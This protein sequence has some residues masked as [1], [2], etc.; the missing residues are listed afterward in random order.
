[1]ALVLIGCK[2]S[3][4]Q[5]K[6]ANKKVTSS[7]SAIVSVT[8]SAM[9]YG[10][11]QSLD[12]IVRF[13]VAVNVTG[14]PKVSLTVDQA[15][16]GTAIRDAIYVSGSG[17][18]NLIFRYTTQD[19]DYDLNGILVNSPLLLNN[20]TIKDKVSN[21]SSGLT[22]S[23][24][25]GA[26]TY[27]NAWTKIVSLDTPALTYNPNQALDVTVNFSAPVNVTGI[28]KILLVI[29]QYPSGASTRDAIYLSGSGTANI[30]F[31]YF[32]QD[33]DYDTNGIS[34]NSSIV[35]NGGT[36][37]N[38]VS[39]VQTNLAFSSSTGL[40][41]YIDA[42][43]HLVEFASTSTQKVITEGSTG[44]T[45]NLQITPASL[46]SISI[47]IKK[48]YSSAPTTDHTYSESSV[49][50]SPGSTSAAIASF[51]VIHDNILKT[52]QQL[53]LDLDIGI[54]NRRIILGKKRHFDFNIKDI[55]GGS[56]P[57]SK[58]SSGSQQGCGITFSGIL[59]CW[60]DNFNGQLGDGTIIKKLI[61]T[62][63]D[64]GVT[65]SQISNGYT[66]TCGI[67][68]TGILKC[69]GGNTDGELGDGTTTSSRIPISID[70]GEAYVQVSSERSHTCAI[71]VTGILKCW[72]SNNSGQ[73]GDGTITQRPTPTPTT[74]DP[75]VFYSQ[76]AAGYLHTCGITTTGILKCW[77]NNVYGQL[78]DGSTVQKLNPT[79]I[80]FGVT[81]FQISN[82]AY[83]TCGLTPSRVLKCWGNNSSGQVGNGTDND[84]SKILT[85]TIIDS[86]VSYYEP[87]AG[88]SHTCGIDTSSGNI[89]CWGENANG[90]QGN[91]LRSLENFPLII[92]W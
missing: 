77:G 81:Y 32:T 52:Q 27:V 40:N 85:P 83:H 66:H 76:I 86:G 25:G 90:R 15:P 11:A 30:V 6:S 79:I 84:G 4:S 38:K 71:T 14:T 61:P 49:T 59:K 53:T 60:G 63:I 36:I 39:N 55:D 42:C 48:N 80:D 10:A 58:I 24:A 68:L 50:F 74:I 8:S 29:D 34:F 75:G 57:F 13:N 70:P 51:D 22:F 82:G 19:P 46:T 43:L 9:T 73:I 16:S 37:Q 3:S 92:S 1:M 18:T 12:V 31:R 65:Y 54:G 2:G 72:G 17:T 20:G 21:A 69:W 88:S 44:N 35:L 78:G 62:T 56:Q 28:P 5:Q 89:K 45:T 26:S 91:R 41:T 67:T 33:P 23:A 64:S 7:S 87:R 47:L